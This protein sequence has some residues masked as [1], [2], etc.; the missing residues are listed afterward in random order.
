MITLRAKTPLAAP[1]EIIV[2]K[3]MFNDPDSSSK[4]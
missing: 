4:P 3:Q 1:S 2:S